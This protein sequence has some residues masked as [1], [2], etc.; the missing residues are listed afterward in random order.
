M[1]DHILELGFC[2]FCRQ[3]KFV[4]KLKLCTYS[5]SWVLFLVFLPTLP[6]VTEAAHTF[7][8]G[9]I[10]FYSLVSLIIHIGTRNVRGRLQSGYSVPA[11]PGSA[12][13]RA[14]M[15]AVNPAQAAQETAASIFMS[16]PCPVHSTPLLVLLGRPL[17]NVSQVTW[18]G[19]VGRLR[20][21]WGV[22][23]LEPQIKHRAA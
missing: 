8:I 3:N 11:L 17:P 7:G 14:T 9:I 2:V 6:R 20:Q 16:L 5:S 19:V 18:K 22:K 1:L 23:F 15:D 13:A 21:T 4:D 12:D 10:H